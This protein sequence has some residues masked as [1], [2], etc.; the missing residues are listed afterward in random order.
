MLGLG[1]VDLLP[2]CASCILQQ[3]MLVGSGLALHRFL[4]GKGFFPPLRSCEGNGCY[5]D[6]RF[7]VL[8]LVAKHADVLPYSETPKC[9]LGAR[10][11]S[12]NIWALPLMVSFR[13]GDFL[14]VMQVRSCLWCHVWPLCKYTNQS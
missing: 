13:I 12:I 6:A 4:Q 3:Q 5:T 1:Q 14:C 8:S 9:P 10:V 2:K 11:P 7:V